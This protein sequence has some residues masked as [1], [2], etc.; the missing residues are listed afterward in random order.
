MLHP[1]REQLLHKLFLI[2]LC[3]RFVYSCPSIYLFFDSYEY[4]LKDIYLILWVIIK[5]YVLY[6]VF[7]VVPTFANRSSFIWLLIPFNILPLFCFWE[8]PS[9]LEW[10]NALISGCVFPAPTLKSAI[11]PKSSSFFYWSQCI[12]MFLY[13][14]NM[15]YFWVF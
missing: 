9:F 3:V 2:L 13:Y 12:F 7:H 10:E 11:S 1:F 15:H 8:F 4:R 14:V 6:S 5:F